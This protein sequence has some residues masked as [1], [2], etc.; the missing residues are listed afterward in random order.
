MTAVLN[1]TGTAPVRSDVLHKAHRNGERMSLHSFSSHIGSG[2]SQD[3]LFGA[4][5]IRLHYAS[6]L[7]FI[8]FWLLLLLIRLCLELLSCYNI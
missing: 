8:M 1:S 5:W 3:C 4:S 2:S 6:E 7:D